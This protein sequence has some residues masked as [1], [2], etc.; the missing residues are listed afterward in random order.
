MLSS[1]KELVSKEN[2]RRESPFKMINLLA[3]I[4]FCIDG[5]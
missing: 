5:Q 1:K 3:D 4:K 2:S